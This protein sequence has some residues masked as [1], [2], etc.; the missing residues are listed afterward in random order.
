MLFRVAAEEIEHDPVEDVGPLPIDRMAGFRYDCRLA[1][2]KKRRE[3][4]QHFLAAANSGYAPAMIRVGDCHLNGDGAYVSE[5]DAV[6]WYRKAAL[7]GD[8]QG[9]AKLKQLGKTQ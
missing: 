5:V 6:S 4:Y 3:A 2:R 1:A 8:E 9:L 7:A